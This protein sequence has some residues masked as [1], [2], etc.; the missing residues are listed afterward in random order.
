MLILLALV[1]AVALGIAMHYGTPDPHGRGVV[2]V[3]AISTA[4]AAVVWGSMT[5]MGFAESNFWIWLASVV[6]PIVVTYPTALWI[7][8]SRM[9]RDVAERARL[10]VV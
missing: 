6:I 8:R 3:P 7:A 1:V 5:W 4:T 9:S 2:L 10:G